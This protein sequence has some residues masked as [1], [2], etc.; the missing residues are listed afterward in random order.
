MCELVV[1]RQTGGGEG[2][3]DVSGS[4]YPKPMTYDY[5]YQGCP[6]HIQTEQAADGKWSYRGW[7][8]VRGEKTEVARAPEEEKSDTE[9]GAYEAADKMAERAINASLR[10]HGQTPM[11]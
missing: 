10:K 5:E 6:I 7:I 11:K 1:N 3:V 9:T 4:D 8:T 2:R